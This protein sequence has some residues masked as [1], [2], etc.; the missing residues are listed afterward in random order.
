MIQFSAKDAHDY[1]TGGA[2]YACYFETDHSHYFSYNS[3]YKLSGD[4]EQVTA[5]ISQFV[6]AHKTACELSLEK[7]SQELHERGSDFGE[8]ETLPEELEKYKVE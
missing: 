1:S 3:Y 5:V 8:W 7:L 2:G 4:Y 6:N